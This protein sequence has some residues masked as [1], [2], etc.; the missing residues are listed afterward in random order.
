ML[1][2]FL[3]WIDNVYFFEVKKELC[4][5]HAKYLKNVREHLR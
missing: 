2:L 3:I 4:T 5:D 1:E